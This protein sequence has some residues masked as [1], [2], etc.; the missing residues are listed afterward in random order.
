MG[1]QFHP[2]FR[3][4]QDANTRSRYKPDAPLKQPRLSQATAII[5]RISSIREQFPSLADPLLSEYCF[6]DW[7]NSSIACHVGLRKILASD[8]RDAW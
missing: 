8:A 2:N 1:C 7:A 4:V 5:C 6:S 3:P